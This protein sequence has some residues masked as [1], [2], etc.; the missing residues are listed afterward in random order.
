MTLTNFDASQIALKI[1]Q[2]T[3]YS[4]RVANDTQVNLGKSIRQEQ[5][6][7]QSA[8]VVVDRQVGVIT[9]LKYSQA[10]P[11]QFNGL[12]MLSNNVNF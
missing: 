1:K 6:T 12:S 8:G 2:A 4:W 5:P 10:N 3:L 7:Y 9:Q 11:Y